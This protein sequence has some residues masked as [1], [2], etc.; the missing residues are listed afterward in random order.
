[1]VI[2]EIQI[3][4]CHPGVGTMAS[5]TPRNWVRKQWFQIKAFAFGGE[6][7]ANISVLMRHC[8]ALAN[9]LIARCELP[10]KATNDCRLSRS[11]ALE[12]ENLL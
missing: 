5:Q 3:G 12:W 2:K 1:M 6:L 7:T 10:I 9:C 4:Y 11:S 8:W